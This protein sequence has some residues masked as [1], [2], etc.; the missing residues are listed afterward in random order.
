MSSLRLGI[1]SDLHRTT[2]PQERHEFHHEHDFTG[3][4]SR[5][6]RALDWFAR[7]KVEALVLCGDL[8]HTADEGAM[9]ALL[10]ECAA[11]ELP[12]IVVSGNHDVAHGE[13]VLVK[14]I[15]RVADDRVLRGD[16]SGEISSDIRIAGVHVTPTSGYDFSRLQAM[17][18]VQDWGD[19]LVILVS[20]LPML[21][22]AAE[23]AARGYSHPGDL[24]DREQAA[25][26]LR[27]RSAPTIVL[28]G[29]IHVRDAHAEGP[30][31]QLTQAAMIEAPFE[32]AVLDVAG[33]LDDG[34][35]ATWRTH[36]T[37][38]KR[39]E[40]EP[41]LVEPS[42]RWRFADGSWTPID[43]EEPASPLADPAV[44]QS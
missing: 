42:G 3:H 20:H 23:V 6:E 10:E 28:C 2:N 33:D 19:E 41:T 25:A 22:R 13:D 43:L 29:H 24:L 37:S 35:L 31:L 26:L 4:P 30:V 14:G 21:S 5:I 15:E 44:I 32:A 18:A 8:T 11:L 27:D 40:H 16:P 38:E 1:L 7:E 36:R 39:Y 12:A 34:V 17:P 9:V